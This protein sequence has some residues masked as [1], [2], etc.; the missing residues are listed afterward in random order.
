MVEPNEEGF[1]AQIDF[2]ANID[3]LS[4]AENVDTLLS[5]AKS[6]DANAQYELGIIY[7]NGAPGVPENETEAWRWTRLAVDQGH[8]CA[9]ANLF[10]M[11]HAALDAG[12][13]YLPPIDDINIKTAITETISALEQMARKGDA[14]AMFWWGM[15]L[16][17]TAP[18]ASN[19]IEAFNHI[20]DAANLGH[21]SAMAILGACLNKYEDS[22]V[23]EIGAVLKSSLTGLEWLEKSW[24]HH[25]PIAGLHLGLH[26]IEDVGDHE[27]GFKYMQGAAN[28][29]CA[30]AAYRVGDCLV[31]GIGVPENLDEGIKWLQVAANSHDREALFSLYMWSTGRSTPEKLKHTWLQEAAERGHPLAMCVYGRKLINLELDTELGVDFITRAAMENNGD[32][33]HDLGRMCK[34]GDHMAQN[35]E[36]AALWFQKA[37]ENECSNAYLAHVTAWCEHHQIPYE[38]VPV[39]TIKRHATGKGN[40]S[41]AAMIDAMHARGFDPADDNEADAL[42]LLGWALEHRMGVAA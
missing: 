21:L 14:D 36:A 9:M 25:S 6:G 22:A 15:L 34:R 1:D 39:G 27:R 8:V 26:Y 33:Q 41:K 30:N 24:A 37:A 20:L 18:S 7:D 42:A 17:H 28:L 4:F 3:K 40:A 31:R 35:R 5:S 29:G 2:I 19:L 32:A 38:A 23:K 16:M 11:H 13:K 10:L 12:S